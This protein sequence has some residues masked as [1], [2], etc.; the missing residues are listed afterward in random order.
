MKPEHDDHFLLRWLRAR[1][2]DAAAAETMLR[3]SMAWREKWEIDT[4]LST[5]VAPEILEKHFPSGS[6]G[7]DKEGSPA[8]C[9]HLA[10]TATRVGRTVQ[11]TKLCR[12]ELPANDAMRRNFK[13]SIQKVKKFNIQKELEDLLWETTRLLPQQKRVQKV[14]S[15]KQ[16]VIIIVNSSLTYYLESVSSDNALFEFEDSSDLLQWLENCTDPWDTV[17]SHWIRT[18]GTRLKLLLKDFDF[19]YP[20]SNQKLWNNFPIYKQNILNAARKKLSILKDVSTKSLLRDYLD[21]AEI[22]IV[23]F[24]GLDVWG[25]LHS[26]SRNDIIRLILRHLENYLSLARKQGQTRGEAAMKLTAIFDLEGFNMRQYAWRPAAEMVFTLLQMYEAN[27]PEILK[28]CFIV[29]APKVFSLAFSIIKKFMNEYT[30]SKIKIYKHDAKKWQAQVLN[31]IDKD[32]LPVHYGGT[33]VDDNG[34]PRCSLIVRLG[35]KVDKKYYS[36]K[37]SV[38]DKDYTRVTIKTGEKHTVHLICANP[39]CFLKWEFGMDNH[40]IKFSIRFRDEDGNETL[41]HGPRKVVGD[42]NIDSGVIPATGPATY[43]VIF[44]NSHSRIR[45]K[46]VFYNLLITMPISELN[47]SDMPDDGEAASSSTPNTPCSQ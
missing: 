36:R 32:Q 37:I 24:A 30:I 1:Q 28:C 23:P 35:G 38:D 12:S 31:V 27:Y 10:R 20:S 3:N 4:T 40:D 11:R 13:G 47:I 45:S 5:W 2:W 44:D 15:N 25:L 14:W 34:D 46:K 7:F 43:T 9:G 29:N 33:L 39:G 41:V 26:V 6:T 19:L 16:K 42:G 22:I 21:L 18:A 17:E 8:P